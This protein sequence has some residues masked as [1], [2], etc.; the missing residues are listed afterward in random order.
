M[1]QFNTTEDIF[2]LA[3]IGFGAIAAFW[4][5]MMVIEVNSR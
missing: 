4:A 5:S 1:K 3:G 2:A